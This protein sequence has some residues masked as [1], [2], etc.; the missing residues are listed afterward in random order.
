MSTNHMYFNLLDFTQNMPQAYV[1]AHVARSVA[2]RMDNMIVSAAR[3]ILR[4]VRNQMSSDPQ[5]P[6]DTL[7]DQ[8]AELSVVENSSR[9]FDAAGKDD[10]DSVETIRWLNALR[11]DWH[12]LAHELTS[13]TCDWKGVPRV[14]EIPDIEEAFMRDPNMKIAAQTQRRMKLSSTRM[15]EAYGMPEMAD[16]F[17]KRRVDREQDR[18]AG[19]AE[20]M[21]ATAPAAFMAF[22]HVLQSDTF[23]DDP[24]AGGVKIK[25][26]A[27]LNKLIGQSAKERHE[28]GFSSMPIELQRTLIDA[29]IT[30]AQRADEYAAGER[31]MTDMEYDHILA[32]VLSSVKTLQQVLKSPRFQRLAHAEAAAASNV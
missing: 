4:T 26:F 13:L 32:C 6:I 18:L 17:L 12:Q 23:S 27:D 29:A 24:N 8:L 28:R 9:W 2:W 16:Q 31:S 20:G 21:K 19:M 14:Y 11:D 5:H 15:A 7:S 1:A 10:P 30:A 25:S 3:S 22:E